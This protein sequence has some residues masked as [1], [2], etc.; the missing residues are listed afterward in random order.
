MISLPGP[1]QPDRRSHHKIKEIVV[2]LQA[3]QSS[4]GLMLCWNN[5]D[6]KN[7]FGE[8]SGINSNLFGGNIGVWR[9]QLYWVFL[10]PSISFLFWSV[11]LLRVS[12]L[13][14][15]FPKEAIV[16]TDWTNRPD[17]PND[18]KDEK[19]RQKNLIISWTSLRLHS[20][21][22][23]AELAFSHVG[24]DYRNYLISDERF[25]RPAEVHQLRGDYSKAKKILGWEPTV[26]FKELIQMMVDT[27]LKYLSR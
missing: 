20:I 15:H 25:F 9:L 26:S 27:D 11:F 1:D 14:S 21:R 22:E 12:N 17:K 13:S 6:A 10:P 8:E 2:G 4:T 16:Q 7:L 24:L 23:F 5:P 3:P 19:A 18:R